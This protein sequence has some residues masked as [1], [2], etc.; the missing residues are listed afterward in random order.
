MNIGRKHKKLNESVV[1]IT[2]TQ[3]A[4]MNSFGNFDID[5]YNK[6]F[7]NEFNFIKLDSGAQ[8]AKIGT[9]IDK[10][11][12]LQWHAENTNSL[13]EYLESV[14]KFIDT[15]LTSNDVAKLT[16][17]YRKVYPEA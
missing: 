14:Q 15:P 3:T 12:G 16:A 1:D 11:L 5:K 17:Q 7:D 9:G 2:P 10:Q 8:M 6:L 13:E 4:Q